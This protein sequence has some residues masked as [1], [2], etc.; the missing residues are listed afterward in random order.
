MRRVTTAL[1][2]RRGLDRGPPPP[3]VLNKP[4]LHVLALC[5]R[6]REALCNSN[7]GSKGG[8]RPCTATKGPLKAATP[9]CDWPHP[10]PVRS[11]VL[12]T[13]LTTPQ[14]PCLSWA[15]VL[16]PRT[17]RAGLFPTRWRSQSVHIAARYPEPRG[18]AGPWAV[19]GVPPPHHPRPICPVDHA[20][21]PREPRP[22][23][24][25][26]AQRA[27]GARYGAHAPEVRPCG[28]KAAA[29]PRSCAR[30]GRRPSRFERWACQSG[31]RRP[32]LPLPA[33]PGSCAA[34][35]SAVRTCSAQIRWGP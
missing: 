3:R 28:R 4:I 34:P 31:G 27:P 29:P 23:G 7:F 8:R 17:R 1:P 24:L 25:P 22:G 15:G 32:A 16:L 10:I 18:I 21:D 6:R 19:A 5:D 13:R 30:A 20:A 11:N 9:L 35:P 14:G 33:Q 12:R 26:A 2:G